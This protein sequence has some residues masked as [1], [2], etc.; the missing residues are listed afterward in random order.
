[1]KKRILNIWRGFRCWC[2]IHCESVG[3]ASFVAISGSKIH[4]CLRCGEE[5]IKG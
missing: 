2:G 4:E 3:Q 5:F 1:M